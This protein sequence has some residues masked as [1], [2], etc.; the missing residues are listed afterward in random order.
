MHERE[1]HGGHAGVETQQ[2][3]G[4]EFQADRNLPDSKANVTKEQNCAGEG[5]WHPDRVDP[6]RVTRLVG[7]LG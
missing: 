3:P 7:H 2:E 4:S 5:E 6:V 1:D